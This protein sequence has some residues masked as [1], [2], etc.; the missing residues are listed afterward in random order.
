MKYGCNLC[1]GILRIFLLCLTLSLMEDQKEKILRLRLFQNLT[2]VE[3][4]KL[5]R[6]F[7]PQITHHP[8]GSLAYLLGTEV[9]KLMIITQGALEAQM[10]DAKG[11]VL[12]VETLKGVDL[13]APGLVFSTQNQLPVQLIALEDVEILSFSKSQLHKIFSAFPHVMESFLMDLGDKIQFLAEKLRMHQF[14]S[15]PQKIAGHFLKLSKLQKST[16]IILPYTLESLS[17]LFGVSR[18]SLSRSLGQLV[19]E[20]KIQRITSRIYEIQREALGLLLDK[21]ME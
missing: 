14:Q 12:K 17:D 9:Q 8:A 18:P 7:I 6:D 13:V 10:P 16:R 2:Q 5:L 20:K 4:L 11:K 19:Q 21:D 15:L 3:S 1:Y